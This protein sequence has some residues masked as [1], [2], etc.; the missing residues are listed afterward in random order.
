MPIYILRTLY[1]SLIQSKLSYFILAWGFECEKLNKIQKRAIRV[2]TCSRYNAHT[3]LLFKHLELLK[4]SD[5]FR[6]NVLKFN[7]KLSHKKV[8]HYFKFFNTNTQGDIHGRETRFNY[9]LPRNVTRLYLSQKCLRNYLPYVINNC[10]GLILEKVQ[11]HCFDGFSKYAKNKIINE[12]E[13]DC[14]IINCYICGS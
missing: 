12:Y 10:P 5:I 4:I 1:C 13:V 7:F 8:P 14:Q 11:T 3:E 2:I 9:L 6:L